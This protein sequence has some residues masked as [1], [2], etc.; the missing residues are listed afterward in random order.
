MG[1]LLFQ[2]GPTAPSPRSLQTHRHVWPVQWNQ[3]ARPYLGPGRAVADEHSVE[4]QA[5]LVFAEIL[6]RRAHAVAFYPEGHRRSE[7]FEAEWLGG[8]GDSCAEQANGE[9][10]YDSGALAQ[11]VLTLNEIPKGL[12]ELFVF[13]P[14]FQKYRD[15]MKQ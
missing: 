14:S 10:K 9:Q 7:G 11:A 2:S 5:E 12:P 4:E 13:R 8:V 3:P 6:D 1:R 15:L